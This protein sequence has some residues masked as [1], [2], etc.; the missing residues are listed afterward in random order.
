MVPNPTDHG[1]CSG[2]QGNEQ[3][4]KGSEQSTSGMRAAVLKDGCEV[5]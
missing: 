4:G 5:L 3:A 1:V 2:P